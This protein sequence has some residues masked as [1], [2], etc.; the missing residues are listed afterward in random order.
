MQDYFQWH[1]KVRSELN[2][3]NWRSQKYLILRCSDAEHKCGGLADR[4]K[5]L[6]FF[7]RVAAKTQRLFLIRWEKP[8]KLE[9]FL[10][11]NILNWSVPEWMET[12]IKNKTVDQCVRLL[13]RAVFDWSH[14]G[15]DVTVFETRVQDVDGGER[16]YQ[17]LVNDPS[18]TYENIYHTLFR[19]LFQPSPP[20]AKLVK[21]KMRQGNLVAGDFAVAHYR[22]FYAIED[23]KDLM[24]TNL[25][26]KY[27]L[28][29]VACASELK[30]GGPVYLASDSRDA[31]EAMKQYAREGN[32]S[33]VSWDGDEALHVDKFSSWNA[34]PP[35]SFY[36]VF[37]DLLIMANSR[38]TAYGQGGFGR[39]ASLLSYNA[40]CTR[41]HVIRGD[42]IQKCFWR[43][44]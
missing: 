5:P 2:E 22:A 36:S 34:P 7:I 6:P 41:R 43:Q 11:P 9:E 21:A 3:T 32:R 27:A 26:R 31:V 19:A 20:I 35:S 18:D 13:S 37:V 29:A 38:C 12:E 39:F 23:K 33:I 42:H 17:Q 28:N 15:S 30:P 1:S 8:A 4:L 40:S 25:L 14:N 44:R 10:L 16:Y 24:T